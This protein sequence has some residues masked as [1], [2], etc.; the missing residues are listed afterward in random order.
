M[1]ERNISGRVT[2][3]ETKGKKTRLTRIKLQGLRKGFESVCV[4]EGG[5]DHI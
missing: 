2:S 3:P 4:V 5:G 1:G